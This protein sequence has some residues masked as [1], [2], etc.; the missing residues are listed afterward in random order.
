MRRDNAGSGVRV[1]SQEARRGMVN[2]NPVD[3]QIATGYSMT[4]CGWTV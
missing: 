4:N 3:V 2:A 1:A